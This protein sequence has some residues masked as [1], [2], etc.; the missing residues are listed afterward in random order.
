MTACRPTPPATDD[1][2]LPR[3]GFTLIELL[4]VIAI[5]A[6]LV[7]IL[8]P[9][10]R[11]GRESAR[12][13]TCLSR[14]RQIATALVMYD[15]DFKT[16]PRESGTS[17]ISL[18]RAQVPA[19]AYAPNVSPK[20]NIAWPFS[21][22]V[23]VDARANPSRADL[24]LADRYEQAEVYQDPARPPDPHTIHFVANGL[25]FRAPG[26]T[27]PKGKA[28]TPLYKVRRP[29]GVVYMTCFIDDPHGTRFGNWY[30]A[31]NTEL[32]IAIFYDLWRPST[33][34][35]PA[36]MTDPLQM[37]RIAPRRH[38]QTSNAIF[39]DGHAESVRPEVITDLAAWDDEDYGR[40]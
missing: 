39:F 32:D 15:T 24:G 28:P 4:V 18:S 35:G 36:T 30:A 38:G 23:Y 2:V 8:L 9:A 5:I 34:N 22:R 25:F 11:S 7:G 40:P 1:N 27:N 21:L 17:E 20:Y 12:L 29:A 13:V 37:P 14:Q 31:G 26:V 3:G 10:L 19:I 6:T 33:V 16:A